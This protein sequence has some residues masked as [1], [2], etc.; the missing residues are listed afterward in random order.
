MPK[1]NEVLIPPIVKKYASTKEFDKAK[2]I[3]IENFERLTAEEIKKRDGYAPKF[4]P[5]GTPDEPEMGQDGF[6]RR[7]TFFDVNNPNF[8]PD[9]P[10]TL[11][12]NAIKFE[13][14]LGNYGLK[15][16]SH[17]FLVRKPIEGSKAFRWLWKAKGDD[18][19]EFVED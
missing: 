3:V 17:G 6:I 2:E 11:D 13:E 4:E 1:E 12:N 15:K 10:R 18:D 8:P 9:K 19:V 7:L 16:G 14:Y 5:K